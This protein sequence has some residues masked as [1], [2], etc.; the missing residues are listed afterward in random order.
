M[1]LVIA[2]QL[3][4]VKISEGE[5]GTRRLGLG[6]SLYN[7]GTRVGELLS[8]PHNHM[9]QACHPGTDTITLHYTAQ[10]SAPFFSHVPLSI[11]TSTVI[12]KIALST[13]WY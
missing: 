2:M 3:S 11:V 9:I 1:L 4:I 10:V 13:T 8:N 6:W 12:I 5:L 7:V